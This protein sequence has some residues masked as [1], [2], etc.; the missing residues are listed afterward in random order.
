MIDQGDMT[1]NEIAG[2]LGLGRDE[3]KFR[4]EMME[5]VGE[6]E[7]VINNQIECSGC[8]RCSD[9]KCSGDNQ[10]VLYRL[11]EKGR[12]ICDR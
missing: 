8:S 2:E 7:F 12:K 5:H 3:L 6:I 10:L 11:T 4:L 9:T 1:F